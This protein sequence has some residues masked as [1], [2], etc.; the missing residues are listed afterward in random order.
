MFVAPRPLAF[1][2]F[3]VAEAP[4]TD[5]VVPAKPKVA[6]AY[7]TSGLGVADMC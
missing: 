5:A 7:G 3:G 2:C 1:K 4:V 6:L